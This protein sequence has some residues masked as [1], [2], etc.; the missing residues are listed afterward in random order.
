LSK[1]QL[2]T[3][4]MAMGLS[5]ACVIHCFLAPSIVILAYG[6]SSFS[7]E[8]ELIHYGILMIAAPI[9]IFALTIG[10]K[11]HKNISVF[12]FG[13]LGL[14]ILTLAVLLE[15]IVGESGEKGLTL[16]GSIILALSHFKN[17]QICKELDCSK[18]HKR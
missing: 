17:H 7:I 16:L 10:Y 8:S 5:M 4:K 15:Y 12:I 14:I 13:I 1:T 11:N 3:D 2:N 9:S 6:V 18:C